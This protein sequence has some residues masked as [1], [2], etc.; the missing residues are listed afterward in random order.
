M[1]CTRC[2]TLIQVVKSPILAPL[3]SSTNTC[4]GSHNCGL[5]FPALPSAQNATRLW[6]TLSFGRRYSDSSRNLGQKFKTGVYLLAKR[7]NQHQI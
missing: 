3:Q 6:R 2:P 1:G 7:K 4:S 5:R